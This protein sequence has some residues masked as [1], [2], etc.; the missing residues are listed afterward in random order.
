MRLDSRAKLRKNLSSGARVLPATSS[1]FVELRPDVVV[2]TNVLL[3]LY[4]C[5]DLF[6]DY[7]AM[8][9]GRPESEWVALSRAR[10]VVYRRQRARDAILLAVLLNKQ[11]ALAYHLQH[12]F[13]TLIKR[14]V[15][16]TDTTSP[17]TH[18]TSLLYRLLRRALPNWRQMTDDVHPLLVERGVEPVE[19]PGLVGNAADTRLLGV[20]KEW[21]VPLITNEGFG[22]NGAVPG[23]LR[24]RARQ[25]GVAVYT[26]SEFV[27]DQ[28]KLAVELPRLLKR[29]RIGVGPFMDGHPAP[30]VGLDGVGLV[31]GYLQHVLYGTL[32]DGSRAPV[33]LRELDEAP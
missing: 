23:R 5:K 1:P 21:A 7:E 24:D 11:R 13:L 17:E 9:A 31:F 12:E 25:A 3:D 20:A 10:E 19:G 8:C 16:P 4:T 18:Y 32:R 22:P 15:P 2:D 26:P 28:L 27:G 30:A 6:R 33:T 14:V 29:L